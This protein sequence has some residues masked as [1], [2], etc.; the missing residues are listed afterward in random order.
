MKFEGDSKDEVR[1]LLEYLY[2]D[3]KVRS[4]TEVST[5]NSTKF[6]NLDPRAN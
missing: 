5:A 6:Q 1:S 2:L 4:P 3:V